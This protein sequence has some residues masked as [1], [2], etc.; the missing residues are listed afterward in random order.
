MERKLTGDC[1]KCPTCR[2]YFNS[3]SAFDRHRIGEYGSTRRCMTVAEMYAAGMVKNTKGFWLTRGRSQKSISSL[4]QRP[5]QPRSDAGWYYP[6]CPKNN[7]S[8]AVF[9][10]SAPAA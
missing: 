10:H 1:N 5:K 2:E 4:T 7:G 9:A 6:T 3:T 8:N